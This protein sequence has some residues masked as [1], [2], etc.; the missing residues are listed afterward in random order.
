MI[1]QEEK[2]REYSKGNEEFPHH[3]LASAFLRNST[4]HRVKQGDIAQRI[5]DDDEHQ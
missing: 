1:A 5:H 3:H 4:Q 2:R